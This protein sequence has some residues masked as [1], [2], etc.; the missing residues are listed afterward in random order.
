[1]ICSRRRSKVRACYWPHPATGVFA[2]SLRVSVTRSR[3]GRHDHATS[4][5]E[6]GHEEG[7]PVRAHQEEPEEP[8]KVRGPR[9]GDRST[10]RAEGARTL[11]RVAHALAHLDEG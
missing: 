4:R 5:S 11:R 1:M 9:R 3:I 7:P 6:E 2:S 10:H 8:G